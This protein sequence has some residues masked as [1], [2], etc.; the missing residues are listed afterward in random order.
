MTRLAKYIL[1]I[2]LILV[3]SIVG[4]YAFSG[5]SDKSS[6]AELLRNDILSSNRADNGKERHPNE[7]EKH[8]KDDAHRIFINLATRRLVLY[9]GRN[10]IAEYSVG[11]GTPYTPTPEG[12]YEITDKQ[13]E[14]VWVNPQD[15]DEIVP[16]GD[17]NPLGYRW[18]G[19][20]GHYGIH[21][22][23]MP[24]SIGGYVSNGC[25]RMHEDDVE[26]LFEQVDVGTP[27]TIKYQRIDVTRGDYGTVSCSVHID[28]LGIMPID[29][30][31]VREALALYGMA[32]F[33]SDN[34]ARTLIDESSGKP[35]DVGKAYPVIV[36]GEMTDTWAVLINDE[37]Y[38]NVEVL[39][40]NLGVPYEVNGDKV[41]TKYGQVNDVLFNGNAYVVKRDLIPLFRLNGNLDM[42][43]S[44]MAYNA[45]RLPESFE[46]ELKL[47]AA[48]AIQATYD[49]MGETRI[50]T[51]EARQFVHGLKSKL[52]ITR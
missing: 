12:S 48:A 13:V 45:S 6:S 20:I 3:I 21:G 32:D 17:S 11:V 30:S 38:F 33:L 9:D 52:N 10:K 42:T 2:P 5:V 40:K 34:A 1:L 7:Q 26:Q 24:Q 43:D 15:M 37:L 35:M 4:G 31:D 23:N 41:T 25:I 49:W 50:F 22:T 36:D 28:A 19:F 29:A 8:D 46:D 51:P 18:M 14:P 39:S 27:L 16:S 44:G 47:T